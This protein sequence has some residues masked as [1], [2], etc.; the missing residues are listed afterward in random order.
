MLQENASCGR[1]RLASWVPLFT[2]A[3]KGSRNTRSEGCLAEELLD[4]TASSEK[5]RVKIVHRSHFLAN[6]PLKADARN[7]RR[8]QDAVASRKWL[9]AAQNDVNLQ[10]K[11]EHSGSNRKEGRRRRK[12]FWQFEVADARQAIYSCTL[13]SRGCLRQLDAYRVYLPTEDNWRECADGICR[14]AMPAKLIEE[15]PVC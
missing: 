9:D 7:T 12:R 8:C 13:L 4:V 6:L 14:A 5:W 3:G 10:R 11:S 15:P 1:F 2:D